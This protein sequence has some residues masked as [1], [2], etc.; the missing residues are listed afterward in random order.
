MNN[1]DRGAADEG[2]ASG[3]V[4]SAGH[5]GLIEEL[6]RLGHDETLLVRQGFAGG[7]FPSRDEAPRVLLLDSA[8]P[9]PWLR[10]GACAAADK[11]GLLWH[12]QMAAGGW[13]PTGAQGLLSATYEVFAAIARRHFGGSL[14]GR[15]VVSGG[16]GL[17][18]G[19][20]PLA[21]VM[22]GAAFLGIEADPERI[23]R[24]LRAGYC[25]IMVTTLEEAVRILRH[26]VH[27]KV[28]TSVALAGNCA[29]VLP[30]M[31]RRGIVPDLLTDQTPGH[32]PLN[33]YLPAG[34]SLGE[35]AHLR[36]ARPAE[37]WERALDSI[38]AQ[39][40][41]MLE[42]RRWGAMVFDFGNGL[43]Q[44]AAERGVRAAQ[45]P[46]H[47]LPEYVRPLYEQ[48]LAPLRWAPLS[49]EASDLAAAGAVLSR[50]FADRDAPGRWIRSARQ[51]LRL[52]GPPAG[53]AWLEGAARVRFA[54]E[55]NRLA[56][57]GD[58]CAPVV[59]A[60]ER[61]E[62][63][64]SGACDLPPAEVLM[65]WVSAC[66]GGASWIALSSGGA[67]GLAG[68]A[69]G[70][71]AVAEGDEASLRRLQQVLGDGILFPPLGGQTLAESAPRSS[72][73][74]EIHQEPITPN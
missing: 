67:V 26:A 52:E 41:A 55:I 1:S 18:G 61:M 14:C 37:Y 53:L 32:D 31:V 17:M 9:A 50:L 43:W 54:A 4:G 25:E 45:P 57:G 15:L 11:V 56:A 49:G 64:A 28:A 44:R 73:R 23:K 6:E 33:G 36:A 24:R 39:A 10:H 5:Q 8:P 12:Q 72:G 35:A 20:Q 27:K 7:R 51:R 34:L 40:R 59:F 71:A 29:E 42:L 46:P 69:F 13:I 48:G 2:Q 74:S 3:G 63:E 16:M 60:W 22:N 65:P 68:R 62:W 21:A 38:A 66:A 47:F 30:E 58:L 19:A 70:Q